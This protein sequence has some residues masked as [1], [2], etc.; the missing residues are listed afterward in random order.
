MKASCF[1]F[2][3]QK[4]PAVTADDFRTLF[5]LRDILKSIYLASGKVVFVFK[6]VPH[7][8]HVIVILK[9]FKESSHHLKVVFI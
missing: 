8:L 1:L 9:H 6:I 4:P 5:I 2:I 7:I 3:K